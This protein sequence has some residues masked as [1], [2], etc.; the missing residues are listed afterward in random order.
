[1]LQEIKLKPSLLFYIDIDQAYKRAD[2]RRDVKLLHS[3]HLLEFSYVLILA[4]LSLQASG[5]M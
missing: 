5:S 4:S 1:M 3:L 2:M